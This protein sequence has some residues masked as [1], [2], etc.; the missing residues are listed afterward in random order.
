MAPA[1]E[2]PQ[3]EGTRR[4]ADASARE[5]VAA[6]RGAALDVGAATVATD[7]LAE[8]DAAWARAE[9]LTG[10]PLAQ[11]AGQTVAV[12]EAVARLA[13]GRSGLVALEGEVAALSSEARAHRAAAVEALVAATAPEALASA[14]R[15]IE[16]ARAAGRAAPD[17]ASVSLVALEEGRQAWRRAAAAWTTARDE[18]RALDAGAKLADPRAAVGKARAAAVAAGAEALA[19]SELAAADAASEG[20]LDAGAVAGVVAAYEAAGRAAGLRREATEVDLLRAACRRDLADVHCRAPWDQAEALLAAAKKLSA[21]D[22]AA[23]EAWRAAHEAFTAVAAR[24]HDVNAVKNLVSRLSVAMVHKKDGEVF[25]CYLDPSV[26]RAFLTRVLQVASAVRFRVGEPA[27]EGELADA[28][29]DEFSYADASKR[30][31]RTIHRGLHLRLRRAAGEWRVQ[32]L[33]REWRL[34]T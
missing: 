21:S 7:A 5:R 32:H 34:R 1:T 25:G 10:P 16:A 13:T 12:Y 23:V 9:G 11:R 22:P 14:D 17:P 6:A 15:A 26:D 31:E 18:L 30:G 4:L 3:D 2:T 8:A 19:R 27:I 20:D 24:A 33:R 28:L 29:V